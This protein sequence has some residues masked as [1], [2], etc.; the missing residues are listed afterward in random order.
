MYHSTCCTAPVNR[1]YIDGR[2]FGQMP[3]LYWV[4]SEC[5]NRC[6]VKEEIVPETPTFTLGGVLVGVG[7][8]VVVIA[9]IVG[10]FLA[11]FVG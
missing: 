2:A 6:G 4:C 1:E 11:V 3:G 10:V 9:L 7:C 8:A 5:G